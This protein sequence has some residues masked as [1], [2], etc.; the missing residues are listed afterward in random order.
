MTAVH[1]KKQIVSILIATVLLSYFFQIISIIPF[2]EVDFSK[3]PYAMTL[4]N[5]K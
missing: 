2:L 5:M 3:L 1:K 4:V